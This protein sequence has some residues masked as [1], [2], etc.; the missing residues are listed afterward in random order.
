M[1]EHFILDY[2]GIV[3]NE[4]GF[5]SDCGDLCNKDATESIGY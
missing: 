1:S 4:D 3:V 5:D 2:G